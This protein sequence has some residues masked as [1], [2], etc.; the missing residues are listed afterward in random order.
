LEWVWFANLTEALPPTPLGH[1]SRWKYPLAL[2]SIPTA[3]V[4]VVAYDT[5]ASA[6]KVGVHLRW[7]PDVYTLQPYFAFRSQLELVLRSIP[8]AL[9]QSALY[10]LGSSRATRIYIDQRLFTLSISVSL[11]SILV[12]YNLLLKE[13]IQTRASLVTVLRRRFAPA[14]CRPCLMASNNKAEDEF[15]SLKEEVAL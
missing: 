7:G 15:G 13:V 2:G 12:Q 14:N 1:L 3:A 4:A 5:F 9:F 6:N 10:L 8:Q 11:V